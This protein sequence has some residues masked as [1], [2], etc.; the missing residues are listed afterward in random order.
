[1]EVNGELNH[2]IRMKMEVASWSE[3]SETFFVVIDK[4]ASQQTEDVSR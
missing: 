3:I 4:V 2:F 1:M